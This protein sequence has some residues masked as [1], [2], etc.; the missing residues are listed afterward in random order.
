MN[1]QMAVCTT[2]LLLSGVAIS[3]AEPASQPVESKSG[4]TVDTVTSSTV[5]ASIAAL[6]LAA[7]PATVRLISADGKSWTLIVDPKMTS[8]S[9]SGQPLAWDQLKVGDAV[10]VRHAMMGGKDTAQSIRVL[11]ASKPAAGVT[12]PKTN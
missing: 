10:K 7:V 9:K 3:W 8:V 12:Q 2:V 6:D 1:R 11:L 4:A 5:E